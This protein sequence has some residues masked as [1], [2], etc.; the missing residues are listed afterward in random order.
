MIKELIIASLLSF[1]P[2]SE[3]RGG[4]P[5]AV[6][7]GVPIITAFV[8]CVIVNSL[9]TL[10][11][12]FLL[13]LMH[14]R[15]ILKWRFYRRT[16][17]KYVQKNRHKLEQHVGTKYELIFLALFTAVPLPLT[18]AYTAAILAW[19]FGLDRKRSFIAIGIGVVIAGIIVSLATIG[20]VKVF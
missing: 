12:F 17:Y 10:L 7:A 14:H 15:L 20:A 9:V 1:L 8:I 19:F 18:G 16:F 5:Y 11:V 2:V 13:D 6:S 4:I 3:L